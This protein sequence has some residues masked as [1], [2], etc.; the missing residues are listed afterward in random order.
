MPQDSPLSISASVIG[1]LTLAGTVLVFLVQNFERAMK[2]DSEI[3]DTGVAVLQSTEETQEMTRVVEGPQ[4]ILIE[5]CI[6]ELENG[7]I[8]LQMI[9]KSAMRRIL[10]SSQWEVDQKKVRKNVKRVKGLRSRVSL[11][12]VINLST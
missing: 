4:E 8:V 6:L 2:L 11:L 7:R 12:Q 10:S 1:I 9:A 3:Y 5:M